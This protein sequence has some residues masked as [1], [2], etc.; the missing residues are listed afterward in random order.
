MHIY[1][2]IYFFLFIYIYSVRQKNIFHNHNKY[3]ILV[4]VSMTRVK[5]WPPLVYS[6]RMLFLFRNAILLLFYRTGKNMSRKYAR[7]LDSINH[8]E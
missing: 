2:L 1:I 4:F 7:F 6:V 3:I 8:K 5:S